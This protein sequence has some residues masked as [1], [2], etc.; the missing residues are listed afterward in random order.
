MPSVSAPTA[1]SPFSWKAVQLRL[2]WLI[3]AIT[4]PLILFGL[5]GLVTG[6]FER[7]NAL[8]DALDRSFERRAHIA[9]IFSE[10][11]DL[12]AG[13]RGYLLTSQPSFLEPYRRARQHIG[14]KLDA[15]ASDL[16]L[17]IER[18]D[19]VSVLTVAV[20]DKIDFV[21]R[22]IELHQAG[23]R[24]ES[25]RLVM[26]G[27]GER[28][29]DRIRRIIAEIERLERG[30][31]ANQTSLYEASRRNAQWRSRTLQTLLVV[32]LIVA[33]WMISRT[34]SDKHRA[35]QSHHDLSTRYSAILNSARDGIII[36]NPSGSIE[37]LNPAAA[38][39]YGYSAEELIR[40]DVGLL[41]NLAPFHGFVE[42]FLKRM[43]RR[44][45]EAGFV[46][47]IWSRRKDDSAFPSDV[48]VSP[49]TLAEGSRYLAVIRDITDRKQIEQMKSE[50]V[51]TVSHELRTPLTSIAG[52]LG[53]LSGGAAGSLGAQ[54]KR[55]IEIAHGNAERLVRLIN[56][57]LDVE[58]I[59]SGK[60][61][62]QIVPLLLCP[63]LRE[64]IEANASFAARFG[65]RFEIEE[66]PGQAAV[67]ADPDR[68]A[69]VVTNL[70]SNAAKFSPAGAAVQVGVV[71]LGR[72]YRITVSD[73]GPGIPESFRA[74]IFGK[75]AQADSSDSRARAGT[76]LGL[77]IVREIVN[78][79]GGSVGFEDREGGGTSFHVD[80]PAVQTERGPEPPSD[81]IP[82]DR[83]R[84]L[85]ADDDPDVLDVVAGAFGARAV[86]HAVRDFASAV[87]ALR[88][89]RF[90]LL[91]LDVDL[92]DGNGL[93]LARLAKRLP[94]GGPP[95]II[96]SAQEPE[97]GSVADVAEVLVKSRVSLDRL[98]ARALEVA[99]AARSAR[100]E[101]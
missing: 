9:E 34:M 27:G 3:A 48:A 43:R 12:E 63:L 59:E 80:L 64:T 91:L 81:D 36:I 54:A 60:S 55:L 50:F 95:I 8:R 21:D 70:L 100:E 49:V 37:S 89:S 33:F 2:P 62:M 31:I 58:K 42:S 85:H 65:V 47:E 45:G 41:L 25:K 16:R 88:D 7:S 77:S 68:L 79:L 22:V 86:I 1:S 57:I 75:F 69:Q 101:T 84:I 61:G 97:P 15:V 20:A 5:G 98:V 44:A 24:N 40:R 4:V 19:M 73:R 87:A 83:L 94:N 78:R 52:A 11:Q 72:C 18:R 93:E 76:G 29:M 67:M 51:S 32:L 90:D 13:E 71:Q 14:S 53:L 23:R 26:S 35:L 92:P 30:R 39:M 74:R 17:D 10:L 6:E 96:F 66:C 99:A 38:R 28:A 46:Q 82:G 56:E